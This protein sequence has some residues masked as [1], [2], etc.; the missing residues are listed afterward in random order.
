MACKTLLTV[1]IGR[2]SDA[3]TLSA[4]DAAIDLARREDAH[5]DV[6]AIG[7]DQ[8]QYGYFYAGESM[9]LLQ[10]TMSRADAQSEAVEAQV[11]KRLAAEDIRWSVDRAVAQ[12]GGLSTMI[13]QR[14]RFADLVIMR[15]PYGENRDQAEEAVLESALFDSA[16]PVLIL[17]DG[18]DAVPRF[19]RVVIAW[20]QSQEALAAVR[21]A[22][23]VLQ[24]A[25]SVTIAVIDPRSGGPERADPGGQ[26][27]QWLSRHGVRAEISVLA[28]TMPKVSDVLMRHA[29]DKN[30]DLVVMGAY[31]KSRF[32]EAIMGGATREM[33]S[34]TKLP[35]L[36]GR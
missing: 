13:G 34:Q 10:E 29:A 20:N 16:T 28:K 31:G 5:L 3:P 27:S 25:N 36:M 19:E 21:Q 11:R 35:I 14:A 17:P 18:M 7:L 1:I 9:M 32:R 15:R 23:P 22:L 26:L 8:T 4:L 30:A 6:L 12:L 24:R 2:D 33:L